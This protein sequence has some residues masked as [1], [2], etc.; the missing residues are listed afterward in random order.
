MSKTIELNYNQTGQ[1]VEFY[2]PE[3]HLGVG[4]V[5]SAYVY[6]YNKSNDDTSEFTPAVAIDSLSTTLSSASGQDQTIRNRLNVTS[7]S[8]FVAGR[9]VLVDNGLGQREVVEPIRVATGVVDLASDLA[10]AYPTA[11]TT[12]KGIRL[13]FT[14]DSTWVAQEEKILTPEEPSY[15]VVW[16]YTISSVA[17]KAQTYLRLVRKQFKHSITAADI[18]RRFPEAVSKAPAAERGLHLRRA[19]QAAEERFRVDV[20]AE[21]YRVEQLA[22]G[23]IVDELIRTLTFYFLVQ[24]Y[25]APSNRDRET[26]VTET[27]DDYAKLFGKTISNLRIP[28]DQGSE[29]ATS[30]DPIQR[31]IF[32]R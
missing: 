21:G 3:S 19:I 4:S 22:D 32:S 2:P 11:T 13:T 27:R 20:L 23:E 7:S 16:T 10:Y 1:T 17:R 15:R 14:V 18:E 31:F 12:I 28:V 9:L 6:A 30:A 5:L 8:G 29:G 24:S 26:V 25:G